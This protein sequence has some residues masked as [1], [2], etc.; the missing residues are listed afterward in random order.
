MAITSSGVVTAVSVSSG[1]PSRCARKMPSSVSAVGYPSDKR[2]KNRSIC[3]SG[4]GNTPW[5]STGFSVASTMN[6][7]GSAWR[8]PSSDTW[9]SSIASRRALCVRGEARLISSANSTCVNTGPLRIS[10]SPVFALNTAPPVTSAG[11][12]SGVNWMRAK[13]APTAVASAF[14]IVVL[15]VPGTSSIST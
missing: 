2:T 15:P 13:S 10:N 3:A 1:R 7:F 11:S 6:S 14:A 4:S 8:S 5:N 12:K 9:R